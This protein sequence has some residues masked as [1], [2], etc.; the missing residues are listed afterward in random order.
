MVLSK[1]KG[2]DLVS[3]VPKIELNSPNFDQSTYLGRARHFLE[4]TNPATVLLSKKKLY[5]AKEL[6][7][8]YK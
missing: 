1:V 7:E 3:K 6:L 5:Q 4:V 8:Q 2:T